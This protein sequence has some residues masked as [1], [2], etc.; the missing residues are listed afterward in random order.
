MPPELES[1]VKK[2]VSGLPKRVEKKDFE[3]IRVFAPK[4]CTKCV[5]L[6]YKG[7]VGVFELLAV[8]DEIEA[9]I[10]P[11]IGEAAILKQA[12]KQGMVT[13]QQDG[14]LKVISGI[15][16]FEEVEGVTGPIHWS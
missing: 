6:G 16:T 5:G 1:K 12:L 13:M 11:A 14:I 3:K 15:S 8:G 9:M 10:S 4:G 7:R 2:F